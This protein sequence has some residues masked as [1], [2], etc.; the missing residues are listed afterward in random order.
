MLVSAILLDLKLQESRS[1][2]SAE[3]PKSAVAHAHQSVNHDHQRQMLLCCRFDAGVNVTAAAMC[4]FKLV[5]R[6][7]DLAASMLD[8]CINV[9]SS[10]ALQMSLEYADLLMQLEYNKADQCSAGADTAYGPLLA[11]TQLT[12]LGASRLQVGDGVLGHDGHHARPRGVL[13]LLGLP[14]VG[15]LRVH[16][17]RALPH[18][19]DSSKVWWAQQASAAQCASRWCTACCMRQWQFSIIAS[20]RL[21][22]TCCLDCLPRLKSLYFDVRIVFNDLQHP[23]QLGTPLAVLIAAAGAA[24]IYINWDSDHQRQVGICHTI[25]AESAASDG[26]QRAAA[27]AQLAK[28]CTTKI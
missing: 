4:K 10:V 15:A 23:Y 1:C 28:V 8:C 17:P 22:A 12:S 25:K 5:L 19:G 7:L 3:P 13:H 27:H 16:L 14:R 26:A 24:A 9:Q 2:T 20:L 21:S 6:V 11:A 18:T